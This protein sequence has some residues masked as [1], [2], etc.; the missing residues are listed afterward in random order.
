MHSDGFLSKMRPTQPLSLEFEEGGK[1]FDFLFFF[2]LKATVHPRIYWGVG[3]I[4]TLNEAM[5]W[6]PGASIPGNM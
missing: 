4:G 1:G 2:S 5:T 6:G 3:K